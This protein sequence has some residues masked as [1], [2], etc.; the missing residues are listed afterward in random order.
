MNTTVSLITARRVW[1]SVTHTPCASVRELA[2]RLDMAYS[3]VSKALR[4][5]RAA[6]YIAF[7]DRTCRARTV[8]VPFVVTGS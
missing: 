8:L 7:A 4:L 5:L 3:Q 2:R 6:G 1:A